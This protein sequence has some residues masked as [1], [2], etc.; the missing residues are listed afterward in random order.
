MQRTGAVF[1]G[2]LFVAVGAVILAGNSA[3]IPL[4][5][6]WPLFIGALAL[7]FF[8]IGFSVEGSRGILMPATLLTVLAAYFLWL[9]FTSW[10]NTAWTWP[11]F[12]AAPGAGLIVMSLFTREKSIIAGL[13]L[14]GIAGA[15]YGFFIVKSHVAVP[16]VLIGLGILILIQA[17][18]PKRS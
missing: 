13:I 2:I 18:I 6:L 11:I 12:I 16:S 1:L 17:F 5:K 9:N 10:A 14:I 3:G 15:C 4:S 7:W 8:V